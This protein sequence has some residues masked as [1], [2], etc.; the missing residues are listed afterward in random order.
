[1]FRWW[2]I[3]TRVTVMDSTNR[4]SRIFRPIGSLKS[5]HS[6]KTKSMNLVNNSTIYWSKTTP[7]TT[8]K[9]INIKISHLISNTSK[10]K[11]TM[12]MQKYQVLIIISTIMIPTL[13]LLLTIITSTTP[14]IITSTTPTIITPTTPTIIITL[15]PTIITIIMANLK[16][17]MKKLLNFCSR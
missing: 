14:T 11:I 4:Y 5:K 8:S 2:V 16:K 3:I 9:N 1:M 12:S 13:M 6:V 7:S 10:T 17:T 15:T